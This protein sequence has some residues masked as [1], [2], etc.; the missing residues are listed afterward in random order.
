M[1]LPKILENIALQMGIP[2]TPEQTSIY[3][4]K[5]GFP[6]QFHI[7]SIGNATILKGIVRILEASDDRRIKDTFSQDSNISQ[8][9]LKTR[10][11][12]VKKDIISIKWPR[13][14]M[15]YPKP[16]KI[17]N[18]FMAVFN[19]IKLLSGAPGLQCKKCGSKDIGSPVL[20][21]GI[22]DCMCAKCIEALEKKAEEDKI[23]YESKP[24]NYVLAVIVAAV[25]AVVGAAVWAGI[26]VGTQRMYWILAV[27]IGLGI[28]WCT[29]KSAGKGGRPVQVIV[30]V[31]TFI[32]VL[33]GMILY[34]GHDVKKSVDDTG[35]VVDW[36][37]FAKN[38]P[39]LLM[40]YK[41]DVIF[42]LAGGL[43]GAFY[44]AGK[45]AKPK[46]KVTIEK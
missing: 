2:F 10:M 1:A 39:D 34:I 33:L 16:D 37:L 29:T 4:M 18:Q 17:V 5:D 28:G 20:I 44:A 8:T 26:I 3:S 36:V 40:L 45:A 31:A 30:F 35:G 41:G 15:G 7:V 9:G 38:L 12:E 14:I 11:I 13:G 27:G 22:V 6:I 42:S 24:T 43:I 32:S 19:S 25:L 21:D 23:Q 46:F